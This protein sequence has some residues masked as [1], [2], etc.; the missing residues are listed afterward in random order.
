R[1]TRLYQNRNAVVGTARLPGKWSCHTPD[2]L[3]VLLSHV[4]R[5]IADAW[6]SLGHYRP[7]VNVAPCAH[8]PEGEWR[9]RAGNSSQNILGPRRQIIAC[10]TVGMDLT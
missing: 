2:R 1:L 4:H 9:A 8:V 7:R 6:S 5:R 10:H 3:C